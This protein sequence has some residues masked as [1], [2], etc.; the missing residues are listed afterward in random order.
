MKLNWPTKKLDKKVKEIK[1]CIFCGKLADTREHIPARNL[2]KD[3]GK[4]NPIT[5]PSCS[6]C[7]KNFSKDEEYFRNVMTSIQYE[8][9]IS[10]GA[11]FETTVKRSMQ[12]KPSLGFSIFNQMSL[13]DI[14][15]PSG[16]YMGRKTAWKLTQEDHGRIFRVLD[17]YIKGLFFHRFDE[18]VPADWIIKHVWLMPK[19]EEMLGKAAK[20]FKWVILNENIFIYGFNSVP[21]THQSLWCLVFYGRPFFFSFVLDPK[22][23]KKADRKYLKND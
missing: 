13:I 19:N 23:A 15:C 3:I 10:A 14:Y 18:T 6:E 12:R 9:S 1:T 2:Y 20:E 21:K 5:V 8:N 4:L 7:N 11:L 17:K 22:T 16:V